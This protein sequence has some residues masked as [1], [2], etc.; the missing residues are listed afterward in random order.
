MTTVAALLKRK[1]RSLIFVSPQTPV[2]EALRIMA[3][4]N[5][6]SI[7][8]SEDDKFKGIVTERDYSRKVALM[9]KNSATTP[10]SEIMSKGLEAA[11]LSDSIEKCMQVMTDQN[12]R[13]M[14]V[15]ENGKLCGIVSMSDVVKET[16]LAQKNTID[17]LQT[18]IQS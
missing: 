2:A 12:I 6:G 10:V 17:H 16:I 11:S 4:N 18:Y 1:N 13:Y 3:E 9:G 15:F 8:I 7:I 5:I 14:P